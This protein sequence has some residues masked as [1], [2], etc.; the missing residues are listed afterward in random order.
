MSIREILNAQYPRTPCT[1]DDM[2]NVHYD[3]DWDT[4]T[5]A[6]IARLAFHGRKQKQNDGLGSKDLTHADRVAI[7]MKTGDNIENDIWGASRESDPVGQEVKRLAHAQCR[8]HFKKV[9]KKV[10][11]DFYKS[12][13][14]KARFD[15][16][17]RNADL[18]A[19][20]ERRVNELDQIELA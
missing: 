20:A 8:K 14:Y 16:Y 2:S 9:G 7:F 11:A 10:D 4:V 3:N 19:L 18:V 1:R 12:D 5:D 15:E 6:M 13:E 17:C